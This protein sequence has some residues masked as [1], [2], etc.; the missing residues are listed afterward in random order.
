MCDVGVLQLLTC[1]C[2]WLQT[3]Q[4]ELEARSAALAAV[5]AQRVAALAAAGEAEAAARAELGPQL[6]RLAAERDCLAN[7]VERL[8][9]ARDV[10]N[11]CRTLS[12]RN[13]FHRRI[14]TGYPPVLARHAVHF[15]VV[16][17]MMRVSLASRP[18]SCVTFTH[19]HRILCTGGRGSSQAPAVDRQRPGQPRRGRGRPSSGARNLFHPV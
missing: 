6:E 13:A 17:F 2:C 18:A 3:L 14:E 10:R 15:R 5:E 1:S 7:A 4:A 9:Q 12:A 11:G 19:A 8:E 16:T